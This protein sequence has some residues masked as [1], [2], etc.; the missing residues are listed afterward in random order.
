MD[1]FSKRTQASTTDRGLQLL[2]T[3]SL[4]LEVTEL[5]STS[6]DQFQARR[7]SALNGKLL[8]IDLPRGCPLVCVD[9]IRSQEINPK[10]EHEIV[11]PG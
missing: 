1:D 2:D 9:E 5:I 3:A 4:R 8:T 7:F 11:I 6:Y 10:S